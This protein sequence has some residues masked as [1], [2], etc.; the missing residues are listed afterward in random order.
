LKTDSL[1]LKL[2]NAASIK[3]EKLLAVYIQNSSYENLFA[4]FIRFYLAKC[5]HGI[6]P[7]YDG[8]NRTPF[9]TTTQR[10]YPSCGSSGTPTKAY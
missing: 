4:H 3:P 5:L 1:I 2:F 8:T 9:N 7:D 6:S 10:G